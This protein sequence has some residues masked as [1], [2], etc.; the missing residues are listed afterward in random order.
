MTTFEHML[1]GCAPVPLGGYLKALGI[2]RLVAEQADPDAKSCWRDE[3]FVLETML[4]MDELVGFFLEGYAPTPIVSPWNGGSGFYFRERKSKEKDPVTGKRIKSGV[5]D[6]PTTATKTIDALLRS[7][8]ARFSTLRLAVNAAK[9]ALRS[10]AAPSDQNKADLIRTLRSTLPE[11]A[12]N[13]IDAAAVVTQLDVE[14]PPLLGS[15]GNDGN[16]DFSTGAMQALLTLI[17]PDSGIATTEADAL[18]RSALFAHTN[19]TPAV[20]GISQF[21]PNA[22][23]SPNG[24]TGF[25]GEAQGNLWDIVLALE[26]TLVIASAVARRLKA[27]SSV[28]AA[29]P[30]MTRKANS[31][32][33]GA[34][35]ISFADEPTTRGEYW[36][37]LWSRSAGLSEI[38]ALFCEGRSVVGLRA[39]GSSLDFARSV[40]QLGVD[41]G[42]TQFQRYGFEQ[43]YGNMFLGVPLGRHIV[44][45][46]PASDL[47]T[48]LEE[49]GWLSRIQNLS[50]DNDRPGRLRLAAH[51]LNEA[52]FSMT[53]REEPFAIQSVIIA[54]ADVAAAVAF[55][56][57]RRRPEDSPLG[58]PPPL[59]PTW[60]ERADDGSPEFRIAAALA[61]LGA[62]PEGASEDGE[63]LSERGGRR[64]RLWLP[65]AAHVAPLETAGLNPERGRRRLAFASSSSL[66]VWGLGDLSRNLASV[67]ERRLIEA[68]RRGFDD[69]PFAGHPSLRAD[70]ADVLAFI[71]GTTDDGRIATLICGLVWVNFGTLTG[72]GERRGWK[73]TL[74]S[75]EHRTPSALPLVYALLKPLFV[76]DRDLRRELQHPKTGE[77]FVPLAEGKSLPVSSDLLRL[78][79]AGRTRAA[80]T[81]ALRRFRASG[82]V[83]PFADSGIAVSVDGRRL[84]ASLLIPITNNSLATVVARAFQTDEGDA[85]AA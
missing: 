2:F 81:S 5:R 64:G 27:G 15:G 59:S 82:F 52:L 23:S 58:P 76:P 24:G 48:D 72:S 12:L 49:R 53:E 84:A 7:K 47:I 41:R 80:V 73:I 70:F 31:V 77:L 9:R 37:P 45:R 56:D 50:R 36:A 42:I 10:E 22:V 38:S 69:K 57:A 4:S 18:L 14:F 34:G 79:M 78:L 65:M 16:L 54:L 30:F 46:N 25:Q 66:H 13:W 26:G 32:G 29:F 74:R 75:R 67:V 71:D 28:R 43:R 8:S 21:T 68:K 35:N 62:W 33:A 85:D 44:R 11:E 51:N 17:D 83:C 40:S 20:G 3:A 55:A 39:A 1:H 19:H 61:S 6:E 60:I 63:E